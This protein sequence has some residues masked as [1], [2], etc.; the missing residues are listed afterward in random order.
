MTLLELII[1]IVGVV[2]LGV[3][4]LILER[5][6]A[7]RVAEGKAGYPHWVSLAL[8]VALAVILGSHAYEVINDGATGSEIRKLGLI[9]I[10]L[11]FC[12][13]GLLRQKKPSSELGGDVNHS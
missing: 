13:S 6:R 4:A 11:L 9:A 7:R 3:V 12:A 1:V 8:F 5:Q 10:V 2:V